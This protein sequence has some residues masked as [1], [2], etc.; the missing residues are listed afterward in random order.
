MFLVVPT[1]L[2]FLA[3]PPYTPGHH[4]SGRSRELRLLNDWAVSRAKSTLILEAIGGMGKSMLCWHWV[5]REVQTALPEVAGVIW[6]SFYEHGADM[7]DFCA[8]AL[9]FINSRPVD[10]YQKRKTADLAAELIPVLRDARGCW[11]W[12]VWNVFW[13]R[14]T[15]TMPRKFG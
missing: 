8:H 13:S 4:F 1:T 14:T 12:T 15:G 3:V 11:S 10:E 9:A 2:N 7:S 5:N 6:Y